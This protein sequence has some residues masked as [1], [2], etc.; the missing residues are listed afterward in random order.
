LNLKTLKG[1]EEIVNSVAFCPDGKLLASGSSD[2]LIKIWNIETG[3]VVK[4]LTAHEKQV[5]SVVYSKTGK[6]ITSGS[7]DKSV[8]IWNSET[9][10]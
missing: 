6:Y 9:G 3:E 1:R 10:N 7:D 2:K 5:N 8:I 4:T